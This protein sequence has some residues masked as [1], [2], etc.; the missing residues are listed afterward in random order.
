MEEETSGRHARQIVLTAS[1][2]GWKAAR[3]KT[4]WE[5]EVQPGLQPS[6][7]RG[8]KQA[9]KGVQAHNPGVQPTNQEVQAANQACKPQTRRASRKPGVEAANQRRGAIH[10]QGVQP[11]N[12]GVQPT[13]KGCNPCNTQTRGAPVQH[14]NK[15]C[16]C[17][18]HKQGVEPFLFKRRVV[19]A[20]DEFFFF[21]HPCWD[22]A[23]CR[24]GWSDP[25]LECVQTVRGRRPNQDRVVA[26]G[27]GSQ[28]ESHTSK[29]SA[30]S[31]RE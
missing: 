3:V 2:W 8:C 27:S 28:S 24:K 9:T 7:A 29:F 5:M 30:T 4:T 12:Q 13:N 15:G 16:T 1:T 26:V 14:T 10:K 22:G 20:R 23:A 25:F 6:Q 11:T 19:R 17:A 31:S 18:T 21:V